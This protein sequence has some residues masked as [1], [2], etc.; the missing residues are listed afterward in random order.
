[1]P[2]KRYGLVGEVS[3]SVLEPEDFIRGGIRVCEGRGIDVFL[4]FDGWR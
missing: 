4:A 2:W 3:M 1:M